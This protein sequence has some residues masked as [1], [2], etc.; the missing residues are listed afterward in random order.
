MAGPIY[1]STNPW[2]SYDL[3]NKY[4]SG[5]HVVW[6][7]EY[8][9]PST[10]PSGS[11]A[12]A[13]APSSSPKGIFDTLQSDC[14]REDSHS[15][16][17]SRYR[18]TFRRL[19]TDWYADGS[20]TDPQREEIIAVTKSNSWRIWRPVLY[21]IP[22]ENLIAAGRVISVPRAGRAAYGPE[23]Q[24]LDLKTNEFDMIER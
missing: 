21:V 7:S 9:D 8:F 19:A 13:I 24:I 18:K 1:Y 2:I 22:N 14:A 16:L 4:R 6:C 23:F 3:V 20:I 5:I 10:A 17:I 12:A 15:A 11:A